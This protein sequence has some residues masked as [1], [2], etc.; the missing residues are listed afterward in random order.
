MINEFDTNKATSVSINKKFTSIFALN[1]LLIFKVDNTK[2]LKK[3][4]IPPESGVPI[5]FSNL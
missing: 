3:I 4:K 2:I 5:F 1:I